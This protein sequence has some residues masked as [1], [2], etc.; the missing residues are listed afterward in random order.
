MANP[1]QFLQNTLDRRGWLAGGVAFLLVAALWQVAAFGRVENILQDAWRLRYAQPYQAPIEIVL[2]DDTSLRQAET[3]FGFKYPWPRNLYGEAVDFLHSA[4]AKAIVFDFLFTSASEDPSEDQAFAAACRRHG[5]VIAGM[6]FTGAEQPEARAAF[7]KRAPLHQAHGLTLG[8]LDQARGVDA[9]QEPLW[10]AF[11]GVGDT[12]FEQDADG[13][14]RRYRLAVQMDGRTY[15]SLALAAALALGVTP[16]ASA[17]TGRHQLLFRIPK[18][19]PG[20]TRLLDVAVSNQNLKEGVKPLVDPARF[21]DKVV[22]IGSS[23]PGL[24]DLRS[25]PIGKDLPGVELQA[26]A[27]DNLMT[28]ARARV[29]QVGWAYWL[30]LLAVM[31]L[32]ARYSFRLRGV[33]SVVPT[34]AAVLLSVGAAAWAYQQASLLVPVALPVLGCLLAYS[35]A[36]VENFVLERQHSRRIEAGFGQFLSPAV[37]ASL[38]MKGDQLEM[39]G[40][41]RELTVYFSDLQ[42][43]TNFSEKL[44]PHDLVVIL[45]EYLTEMGEVVVGH[46]DGTVDKYIG[47]AIMAFWNAPVDQPDHAWRGCAAAWACQMRLAQIQ[48]ALKAKGLDAGD[49]GL[50]M[51]VGLN[52]GPAVAG[53]MGS[54]RKLNYTVM[55]DTVNTASRLEGANKPYGTR[56]MI[57]QAT[58][59]AAGPQV[60]TRPLDYLKVKGK[61]DAT[62]VYE[63][64]G[65]AGEPGALYPRD[66]VERWSGA[67]ALYKAGDFAQALAAFKA[68]QA[69][70]PKDKAAALFIDRCE[71]Y[72][73]EPPQDWDG[74]YTMKTK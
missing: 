34:L 9:P 37:L 17:Y 13:Q 36:A 16:P 68:C 61:A 27:L 8:A 23:A 29:Y 14:G 44:S 66:Y 21:K 30:G 45:N 33:W 41:T 22:F 35:H 4:G 7:F 67:L 11:A 51:R 54:A 1:T 25:S 55:G 65:L 31:L 24:M 6:Q 52:T 32:I 56:I 62:A 5:K 72:L 46:Y 73:H 39:G 70:A 49:E 19:A 53:L 74:V 2:L 42:G 50:V 18:D 20:S 48:D 26:M 64:I 3:Q 47:D 43:F 12:S 60:L 63:V 58:K 40:E 28:G 71:H 57:S 38:K 10:S 69:L 15:P 59:D